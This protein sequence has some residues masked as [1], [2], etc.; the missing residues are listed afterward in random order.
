MKDGLINIFNSDV[1][2]SSMRWQGVIYGQHRFVLIQGKMFTVIQKLAILVRPLYDEFGFC[3][4]NL[5]FKRN[6]LTSTGRLVR[7]D[8]PYLQVPCSG[9]TLLITKYLNLVLPF[10][11]KN[12]LVVF[13][14]RLNALNFVAI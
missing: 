5:S 6:S 8:C 12:T 2:Q 14:L 7:I 1:V 9:G 11:R 10:V 4:S 3:A 13:E